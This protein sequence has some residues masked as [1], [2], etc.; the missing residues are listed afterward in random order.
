[1]VM[2][3]FGIATR[4]TRGDKYNGDMYLIKEF[5]HKVLISLIDG[6]GHGE[7]AAVA[8]SRCVKCIEEHYHYGLKEIFE[9]CDIELRKTNGAVMGILL[10]E[11]DY[12][13]LIY[14]GVGNIAASLIGKK[15][16]QLISRDGIVGYRLPVIKEY[17]YDYTPGDTILLYSDGIS[18]KAIQ[19]PALRFKEQEVQE[20]AREIMNL[21]AKEEDD[22]SVIVAR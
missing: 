6:L 12:S 1:M 7:F 8:A 9:Y 10:I 5:D 2:M 17:R 18:S 19:Y 22:A 20:I 14:A 13:S 16:V 4:S 15:T 11:F 3:K 21:F